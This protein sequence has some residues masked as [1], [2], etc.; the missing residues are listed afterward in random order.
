MDKGDV[1]ETERISPRF[2]EV[3]FRGQNTPWGRGVEQSLR[4]TPEE[5]N[6]ESH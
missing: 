1:S 5:G 6:E 2:V 3:G 4:G